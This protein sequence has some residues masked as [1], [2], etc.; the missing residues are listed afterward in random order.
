MTTDQV[1][2]GVAVTV[3]AYT[4]GC[5]TAGWYLVRWRTGADLR[6]LG[7]GSVGGRNTSRVVGLR[8]AA[9]AT[10]VDVT[11]GA[12]AIALALALAPEWVGAA[13]VAVV[14]GHVWPIQLGRRGGRGLAPALGAVVVAAPTVALAIAATF[15]VLALLGRSTL[16]PAI[17]ATVVAPAWAVGLGVPVGV[18]AGTAGVAVVVV[19]GHAEPL[20]SLAARRRHP[21]DD[22]E[23]AR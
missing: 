15:A 17:V 13:M 14:A 4:F 18:V 21:T 11:K 12:L 6:T 1:I 2:A 22:P 9:V 16:V 23:A 5:I 7:S 8:W 10:A 3:A 20:R 19:L